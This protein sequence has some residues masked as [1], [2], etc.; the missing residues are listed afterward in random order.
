[1]DNASVINLTT[2]LL[3]GISNATSDDVV[4]VGSGIGQRGAESHQAVPVQGRGHDQDRSVS[5]TL[6][7]M[8][9]VNE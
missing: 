3:F 2:V 9:N 8:L 6:C 1:M 5:D 7:S 4:A